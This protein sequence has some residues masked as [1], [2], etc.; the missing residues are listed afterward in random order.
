MAIAVVKPSDDLP[1]TMAIAVVK[2]SRPVPLSAAKYAVKPS[3]IVSPPNPGDPNEYDDSHH[4][5]DC[6]SVI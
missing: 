6:A 4:E 3:P 2:P 5:T 1:L